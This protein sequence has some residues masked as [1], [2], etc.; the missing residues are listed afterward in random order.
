MQKKMVKKVSNNDTFYSDPNKKLPPGSAFAIQ[1]IDLSEK[2]KINKWYYQD[3]SKKILETENIND[4]FSDLESISSKKSSPSIK[5]INEQFSLEENKNDLVESELK[6]ININL[7]EQT[8]SLDYKK[9]PLNKLRSIV[10]EKGLSTDS[11][12]L[13][14]NEILK[15]LG[16]E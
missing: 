7:E 6:T 14:K 5:Q 8:D 2:S 16:V 3:N 4:H 11:T 15:L 9:L 1:Y 10:S 12:K 13:K